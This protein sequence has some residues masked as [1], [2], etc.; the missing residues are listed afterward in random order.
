M[1]VE[2][3]E[4][5]LASLKLV[6]MHEWATPSNRAQR[7]A[8]WAQANA[9]LAQAVRIRAA[10]DEQAALLQSLKKSLGLV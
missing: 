8:S 6:R 4:E 10:R 7:E 3:L 9:E 5:Q 1:R 2:S